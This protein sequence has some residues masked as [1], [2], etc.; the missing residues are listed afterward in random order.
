[1]SCA[2]FSVTCLG[3]TSGTCQTTIA[4]PGSFTYTNPAPAQ[5]ILLV[6]LTKGGQVTFNLTM[7]NATAGTFQGIQVKSGVT[8]NI[9]GGGYE[10][11]STP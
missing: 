4:G 9:F 2:T 5:A 8:N 10:T 7:S 1:M 11:L 3:L 6:N